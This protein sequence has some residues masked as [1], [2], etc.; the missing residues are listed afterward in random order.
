MDVE[1]EPEV[2]FLCSQTLMIKKEKEGISHVRGELG[3]IS[4]SLVLE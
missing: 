2:Y 4:D 1:K 3:L